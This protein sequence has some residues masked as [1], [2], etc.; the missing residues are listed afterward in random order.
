LSRI[1]DLRPRI[2]VVDDIEANRDLLV[3]RLEREGYDA[4][5]TAGDGDE[6]L[7]RLAAES[8]DLVLLDVMMPK[9]DGYGVL[10]QLKTEGRLTDLPVIVISANNE[11]D[12]VVR[13]IELGAVD[14]LQKPFNP[15]L[16]RARVTATLEKK[17]LRDE[18]R[19]HLTRLNGELD[20][21]R[22]LQASMLPGAFPDPTA[23]RPV[24]IFATM[25]PA[26]EIGGDL[27]DFF[28]IPGGRLCFL[29]GDVSGKGI[30]AA[31][32]MARTKNLIRLVTELLAEARGEPPLPAEIID[33]VNRE[34]ADDN[35]T[36]MFVTLFFGMLDPASG[37][38]LYCNA[39]HDAPFIVGGGSVGD[40]DGPRAMAL[41]VDID[42]RYATG[43]AALRPGDV[44]YL[45]TDGITEAMNRGDQL[46]SRARL[47]AALAAAPGGS[48]RTLVESVAGAVQGFAEGAPQADDVTALAIRL[49]ALKA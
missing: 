31:L 10:Q 32:F 35:P 1:P 42:Q 39:G 7:E 34:L 47:E 21:A 6:A 33:R 41:G 19:A 27:Y 28:F 44:L 11:M 26:R 14:Y 48:P 3:L 38:L 49:T 5:A 17:R 18:V 43:R 36:M 16:L 29:V 9:R 8:F 13:C 20:A 15:T 45:F 46:F 2:L 30:P 24:E 25:I 12:S 22:E 23:E 37:E 40:L 4:I